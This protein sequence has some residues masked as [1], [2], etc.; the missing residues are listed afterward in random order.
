MPLA[1]NTET[2]TQK[3]AKETNKDHQQSKTLIVNIVKQNTPGPGPS[4]SYENNYFPPSNGHS[5]ATPSKRNEEEIMKRNEEALVVRANNDEGNTR[6]SE[7]TLKRLDCASSVY[8]TCCC[9]QKL[10]KERA[11]K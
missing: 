3:S 2:N 1:K 9:G 7:S 4:T 10:P 8:Q 11:K 6:V 5:Y